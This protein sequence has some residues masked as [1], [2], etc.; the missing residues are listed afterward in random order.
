MKN[1]NG[2]VESANDL[3]ASYPKWRTFSAF[4]FLVCATWENDDQSFVEVRNDV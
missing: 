1:H 2:I 3:N 4:L